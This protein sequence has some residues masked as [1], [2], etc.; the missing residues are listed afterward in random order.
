MTY[1]F[2]QSFTRTLYP[3]EDGQPFRLPTQNPTIYIFA[4]EPDRTTAAAGTG[5]VE[6]VSSW[7]QAAMSPYGCEYSVAAISD[8]SPTSSTLDDAA[9][10]RWEALNF[11]TQTG[12]QA[13]LLIRSFLL[14]RPEGPPAIPGTTVQDLLE[15]F[16]WV[17]EYATRANLDAW[18][19]QA[20]DELKIEL[21]GRGH[22]WSR[23]HNLHKTR[24]LLAYKTLEIAE[25]MNAVKPDDRHE[26]R[27]AWFGKRYTALIGAV[28][29]TADTDGDGDS[30]ADIDAGMSV[31]LIDR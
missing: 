12:A 20:Q 16:P 11:Y 28:K 25:S 30:D 3:T 2:G 10:T 15:A 17:E 18:L 7:T 6:T 23:I 29:L 14:D 26:R 8:P 24:L 13:Q 22:V 21:E 5:A 9:R 1:F 31:L 19:K 4:T 27:A